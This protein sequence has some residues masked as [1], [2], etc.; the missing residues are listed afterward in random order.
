MIG[1]MEPII[2][3][4]NL[5]RHFGGTVAVSDLNLEIG[6]GEVFGFLGH[7]G[8]GKT[9]T[10]RLLNG[11]L[12][13]THGEAHL[14]GLDPVFQGPAVR[15]QTGILTETPSLD[16]RL[17]ART[18]LRI[19]AQ[20]YRVPTHQ[21]DQRV[22]R[23]L[24]T[25]GLQACADQKIGGLSKGTRQRLALARTLLHEPKLI[26]LDEPTSGLDP[27]AIRDVHHLIQ[28]L[29]QEQQRTVFLCTHNLIEAQKLCHRVAVL[30]KGRLL[31]VGTPRELTNRY[32]RSQRV[33]LRISA[34]QESLLPR[35]FADCPQI[36]FTTT[37][38][39]DSATT[40]IAV[41]GVAQHHLPD[42]LRHLTAHGLDLFA[43]EP[44]EVSLEDVY[45]ALQETGR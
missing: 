32:S 20:I 28:E 19:F 43:V 27:V 12:K 18:S 15:R 26:F 4:R 35:L 7:N 3:T 24:Q 6:V 29:T 30:A 25:F 38:G 17:T 45:F 42:F 33:K 31:A 1:D 34:G 23:L 9:T 16:D 21:M 39:C 14:F 2:Y 11:I 22:D 10:V 8:A 40:Q 13:P 41:Q 44:E 37:N 36:R 5:T